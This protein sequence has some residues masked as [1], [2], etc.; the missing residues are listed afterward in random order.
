[1]IEYTMLRLLPHFFSTQHLIDVMSK[2]KNLWA[3]S[4][5]SISTSLDFY[6][7]LLSLSIITEPIYGPIVVNSSQCSGSSCRSYLQL[8]ITTSRTTS[9]TPLSYL[10]IYLIIAP[11]AP[12][13]FRGHFNLTFHRHSSKSIEIGPKKRS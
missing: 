7:F 4:D 10:I 1:M 8:L 2:N 5:G 12:L 3:A 13:T 11:I 6:I 9:R